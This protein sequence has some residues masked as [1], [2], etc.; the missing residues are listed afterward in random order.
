MLLLETCLGEEG[1]L[2]LTLSSQSL[3][4][5]VSS[6]YRSNSLTH[7]R[8]QM[9]QKWG[10]ADRSLSSHQ[11]E[12]LKPLCSLRFRW[13][14]LWV[15]LVA[16]LIA[17]LLF[18]RFSKR[19]ASASQA[20]RMWQPLLSH[21]EARLKHWKPSR[22]F[23]QVRRLWPNLRFRPVE[24]IHMPARHWQ[25]VASFTRK[26]DN[27]VILAL[28]YVRRSDGARGTLFQTLLSPEVSRY[29]LQTQRLN[30][31]TVLN[32]WRESGLL[33]LRISPSP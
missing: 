4:G 21:H 17:A 27:K 15:G 1:G 2:K 29:T 22:N 30:S 14:I 10:E 18:Q 16:F 25:L 13:V 28:S 20:R 8:I 3:R 5:A 7:H 31:T 12:L 6:F 33:L 24:S 9:L 26:W 11:S 19:Y 32:T 23:E